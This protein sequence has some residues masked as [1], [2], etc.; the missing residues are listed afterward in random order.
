MKQAKPPALLEKDIQKAGIMLLRT[1]GWQVERRN[2]GT[3]TMEY[4]GKKRLVR[5]GKPGMADTFGRLPD[6]RSFELEFK[7]PGNRPTEAQLAWLKSQNGK[8][9]CAFWVD[10]TIKLE[11]IA[12]S[13]MGGRSI[14]WGD[15]DEFWISG[16][17]I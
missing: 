12:K 9:C 15:G 6:E 1:L 5:A 11:I 8:Y 14:A 17:Q 7:R 3:F 16:I 4:K 2:T 13:L 10:S